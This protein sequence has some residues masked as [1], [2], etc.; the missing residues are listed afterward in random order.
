[1]KILVINS[2]SSS[3]KCQL[4]DTL[5]GAV[6][7]RQL[8][9][10]IG[11]EGSFINHTPNGGMKIVVETPIPD[12]GTGIKL[13]LENLVH[14]DHGVIGSLD[15]IDAI[16]HR[17]VHGADKFADS[18]VI[19]DKVIAAIEECSVLA[20]LHNPPNLFG[21]RAAQQNL[22]G[23]PNVAVFDTAFHQ[24]MPRQAY[25]YALPY[26]F[27]EKHRIRRY[28]FHGTSHHYVAMR[29][30]E[31][32]NKPFDQCRIVT[33]HLGNGSSITAVCSGHSV[34]TSLGFG[35]MCGVP[36]GTRA[37]DLDPAIIEFM[38]TSL[39]MTPDE[40]KRVL[41][42]ES[43][44]KGLSGTT[45]DLRDVHAAVN[46]GNDRAALALEVFTY[47]IKKYIGAYAAAMG[48]LDAV[49]FTAG[50]GEKDEI[51]RQMACTGLE[52]LGIDFDLRKN[53]IA[54]GA[55]TELT[56]PGSKVKVFLIPTDEEKMI[57]LE[58]ERLTVN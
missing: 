28:G 5:T 58:T 14:P 9:E 30:A 43:G 10:R 45:N 42:K 53:L 57:A 6:L 15:E 51:V 27:Y 20:P 46:A 22:P 21:I 1:M 49:V 52:F 29:S 25:I 56:R 47:A 44:I 7:A 16:G 19:D 38:M 8:V 2:G 55:E 39:E 37:G 35:T 23:K 50:I 41:Y 12:H 17:V 40:I 33:C 36:M 18:V 48:G 4:M 26:E 24:R 34:D 3:I 11:I 31:L 32:L 54:C 13:V